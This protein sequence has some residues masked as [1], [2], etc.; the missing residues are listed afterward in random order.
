MTLSEP[1]INMLISYYPRGGTHGA[2]GNRARTLDALIRDGYL[3][4]LSDGYALSDKGYKLADAE[5]NRRKVDRL[6]ADS[7]LDAHYNDP[8]RVLERLTKDLRRLKKLEIGGRSA[9]IALSEFCDQLLQD[10]RIM[11]TLR[12]ASE[13]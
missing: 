11:T 9:N 5:A 10:E 3:L 1:K 12:L 8:A 6:K 4:R 7:A 2:S 13:E